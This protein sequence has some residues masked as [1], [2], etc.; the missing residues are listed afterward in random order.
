MVAVATKT[1]KRDRTEQVALSQGPAVGAALIKDDSPLP[2]G[3]A[4][5]VT[6]L[7]LPSTRVEAVLMTI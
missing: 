6:R 3:T 2:P 4:K 7:G 1:D 5:L